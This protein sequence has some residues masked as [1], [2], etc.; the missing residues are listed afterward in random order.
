MANRLA[1]ES[2]PYLLQHKDNPVDWY[3]WGEEAFQVAAAADKPVFVSIGYAACHWCHVMEHESFED[4]ATAALMNELFINIK[5]DREE[6]P[7]V[8]AVYMNAIQLM[9]QGGGWPLSAFCTPDGKPFFL[10]TYFP[11]DDRYGRPG[12]PNI[13]R[14]MA[15]AWAEQREKVVENTK[16]LLDGLHKI[17][18]HFRNGAAEGQASALEASDIITAGR[19]LAQR[20]DPVHGGLGTKPKFP[21][22]SAHALLGRAGRLD[23][24]DPAREAFLRQAEKMARGGIYDHVGGGFARYA[25]DERWLIPHFE[26]MLYDNAQLLGIYGDAYA[27]TGDPDYPRVID[28]TITWLER[29][30]Q[31]QSGALYASQDADSEGEEGKYYV[32]TPSQIEAAIGPADA[33]FFNKSY[34]VSEAGNF[35]HGTTVLE[36][37]SARGPDSDEAALGEMRARLLAVRRERVPPATDTKVLAAWN[38]LC[39][40]GLLRAW[41]AT[42]NPRALALARTVAEFLARDMVYQDGGETRLW[43]VYKDG[44]TKLEGT[45]D[46]YAFVA[47]AFFDLAEA[48]GE[49]EWWSRATALVDVILAR[50]Y[51]ERDGV[52]IF[53]MTPSDGDGLLVHRPESNTDGAL[54]SGA[55]VAVECLLRLGM[56]ADDRRALDVAERYLA[57]R[58]ALAKDNPFGSARLLAALD[59]YLHGVEL[60]VTAGPGREE[61]LAAARQAYAPTLLIAGDWAAPA[62]LGGKTNAADGRAQAYVCRG[63]T[64]SAPV[65]EGEALRAL[66]TAPPA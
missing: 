12:F 25:V 21:S 55:S 3:P 20:S 51:E 16:A 57:G 35:E 40:S 23:F 62:L 38:G 43:R 33:I 63:Q 58:A 9:G 17:D 22:S 2:S 31:H 61:L 65:T 34:G 32:W 60:V 6:R 5:V 30:M 11:P 50:F 24:G 29:E 14:A 48:T 46:D 13:L 44:T 49:T 1:R 28:E 7:D 39:V 18:A 66:L 10:G 37:V 53:F 59:L 41:G 26:K 52:G 56:V 15:Q 4:E 8:D 47:Q 19:F 54:P 42:Q 64:C 36:R 27:L 45:V